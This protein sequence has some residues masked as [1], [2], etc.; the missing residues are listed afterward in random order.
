[1]KDMHQKTFDFKK[2]QPPPHNHKS[3]TKNL[4]IL[5]SLELNSFKKSF[6]NKASQFNSF[7]YCNDTSVLQ[8][9]VFEAHQSKYSMLLT[10]DIEILWKKLFF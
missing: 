5:I 1:M 6:L 3:T 9:D 8:W 2:K 4:L 10:E 7:E